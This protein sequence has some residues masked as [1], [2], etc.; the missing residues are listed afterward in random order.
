MINKSSYIYK[1]KEIIWRIIIAF[2]ALCIF[3]L[4]YVRIFDNNFWGDE[5]FTIVTIRE[6]FGDIISIT[7]ADVHPPLYYFIL[8]F[9]CL[10][11]GFSGT[12]YHFASLV[13]YMIML[14]MG[15]TVIRKWFNN[16]TSIIFISFASL[17]S[18]STQMNV[19][20]R[21]YTWG[22]LFVLISFLALYKILKEDR[23]IHWCVFV[24]ASL[25]AAYT[26][27][28]CLITVAFFYVIMIFDTLLRN[29][30]NLK[31]TIVSC[32]ITVLIY[33]PWLF[34]LLESFKRTTENYWMT[35]IESI[36]GSLQN[37]FLSELST[38]FVLLFLTCICLWG[39]IEIKKHKISDD[40]LWVL[41]GVISL[42]GTI[43]VGIAISLV[44]RPMYVARYIYPISVV[45]WLIFGF[46]IS[47]FKYKR[48]IT[49]VLTVLLLGCG[50]PDYYATYI[51]E[52][53]ENDRLQATLEVTS[54][55]DSN[56]IIYT[57]SIHILW[58][59]GETYYPG[60]TSKSIAEVELVEN[61]DTVYWIF[62]TNSNEQIISENFPS[63]KFLV[64]KVIGNGILGTNTVQVYKV[65][66]G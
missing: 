21:M 27:Y 30:H 58:T 65:Y 39:I 36:W 14:I 46:C 3:I 10:I 19:E 56:D 6:N 61:S 22:A 24:I 26:H 62:L 7:A 8:R 48:I 12:V 2:Y 57:D 4:H 29:K 59:I 9:F 43:I 45:I 31:K 1:N 55:M 52:K 13:P 51:S 33:L 32:V 64:E 54:E 34:V 44:V 60:I 5:A 23:V 49:L 35:E 37:I 40:F 16:E 50:L 28:Y 20:V 38:V 17:L 25:A 18:V 41:A 15:V 53:E 66:G 11:F 47:K 63:D 42:F